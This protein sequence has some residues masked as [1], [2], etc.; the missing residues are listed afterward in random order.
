[1]NEKKK[2]FVP[3]CQL[4]QS[5]LLNGIPVREIENIGGI[6]KGHSMCERTASFCERTEF[7]VWSFGC[8]SF[9]IES[10]RLNGSADLQK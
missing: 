5:T 8:M 1:M 3:C 2:I 10:V 6:G 9:A 4:P 7:D